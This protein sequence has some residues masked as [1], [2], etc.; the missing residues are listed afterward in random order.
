MNPRKIGAF[1]SK[2]RRDKQLTQNELAQKIGVTD[3]AISKWECG[4]GLPDI[5]ILTSLAKEL[6]TSVA[7]LLN[8]ESYVNDIKQKQTD[9]TIVELLTY[10][11]STSRRT[12]G[13]LL[14]IFGAV[15]LFMFAF[16]LAG[17]W[18][19]Y[20]FAFGIVAIVVGIVLLISKKSFVFG[21]IPKQA[22]Q[23]IAFGALTIAIIL[24]ALP[25]GAVLVFS[26]SPD[27]SLVRLYSYFNFITF[28][29]ANF[30]PSLTATLTVTLAVMSLTANLVKRKATRLRN[31]Q[32][33]IT[34]VATVIS[35]C[36][37]FYGYEYVTVI[38]VV[39]T[40]LLAISAIFCAIANAKIAIEKINME[41]SDTEN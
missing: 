41:E 11:H 24:E 18:F 6:D 13:A 22:A 5:A 14:V 15:M 26:P 2:L 37:A 21:K 30:A 33:I 9:Q 38:G 7:E 17:D 25:Y 39:I 10:I 4:K 19:S 28:A 23:W 40:L 16:S 34:L 8:G 29:Y 31:T 36:P 3:K 1:I 20:V 35:I 12:V 32:F 27:E